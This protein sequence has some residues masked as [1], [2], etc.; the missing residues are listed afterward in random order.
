[1]K[2]VYNNLP[3]IEELMDLEPKEGTPEFDELNRLVDEVAE[4]EEREEME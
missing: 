4:F 1:M 3:R 2:D